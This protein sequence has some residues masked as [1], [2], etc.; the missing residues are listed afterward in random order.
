MARA[1]VEGERPLDWVGSSKKDFLAFPSPVKDE[2]GAALGVAQFGG[3]HPAANP[4]RDKPPVGSKSSRITLE[5]RIARPTW[6]VFA[7]WFT[8][9]TP[10]RRSRRTA[11]RQRCRTRN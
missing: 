3:K 9:S 6:F 1:A 8:F 10:F 7:R 4:G 11:Q 5:M 2:M